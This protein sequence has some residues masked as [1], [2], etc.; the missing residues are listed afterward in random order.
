LVK[1]TND[2]IEYNTNNSSGGFVVLSEVYYPAGW[3]AYIDGKQTD[4]VKTNYFMR[5]IVVPQGKHTIKLTFEPEA[6]K[7]GMNISYLSS[8]LLIILVLGGFFM[9]W[10]VDKKKTANS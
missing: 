1:Y 6:V 3:N 9:Q 5:G 4:I 2:E 10:W 7:R 8:W